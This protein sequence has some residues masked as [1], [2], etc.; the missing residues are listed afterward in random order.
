[1]VRRV[2]L[3]GGR[4]VRLLLVLDPR[5]GART[6]IGRPIRANQRRHDARFAPTDIEVMSTA[7]TRA[8]LFVALPQRVAAEAASGLP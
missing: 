5:A 3:G 4:D 8:R 1:M 7:S 2:L 6:D